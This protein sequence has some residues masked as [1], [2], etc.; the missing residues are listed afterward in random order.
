MAPRKPNNSADGKNKNDLIFVVDDE[1]MLLELATVILEPLGYHVKTFRDPE[2]AV[3]AFALE[4]PRPALILT[5][6]AMHTMNG[7]ELIEA[8]RRIQPRQK[9]L[10]VSGTV[11][12]RVYRN[13]SFKPDSFLAKPYQAKQLAEVVKSLL[14]R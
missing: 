13:S 4:D 9:I 2:S 11:D 12:E 3:R 10:L 6:Y 7:L 5:D 1:P 8:C 14:G